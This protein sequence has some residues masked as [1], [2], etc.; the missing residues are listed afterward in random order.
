MPD[1]LVGYQGRNYLLEIKDGGK[2]PSARKL[3][4][5]QVAWHDAWRG[6]VCVVTS[7]EEAIEFVRQRA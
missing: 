5:D 6:A 1:L 2:V 4:P 3:T 7:P